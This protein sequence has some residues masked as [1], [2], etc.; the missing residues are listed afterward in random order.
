MAARLVKGVPSE[1][2]GSYKVG[3][4]MRWAD[5]DTD[6]VGEA[7]TRTEFPRKTVQITGELVDGDL[8]GTNTP[9]D[10]ESWVPL[11]DDTTQMKLSRPGLYAVSVNPLAVR[12]SVR[13]GTHVAFDIVATV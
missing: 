13:E 10:P 11:V 5:M 1:I 9:E 8:E 3:T 2:P 12:P 6:S 7:M 4:R